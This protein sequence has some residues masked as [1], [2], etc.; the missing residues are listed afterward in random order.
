MCKLTV[1]NIPRMWKGW[2]EMNQPFRSASEWAICVSYHCVKVGPGP[3]QPCH[4]NEQY[5]SH[6]FVIIIF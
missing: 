5:C 1:T 3:A 6:E 4:F 2:K